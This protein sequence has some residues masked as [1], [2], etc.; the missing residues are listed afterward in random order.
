[1]K[2]WL[3][4][5]VLLVGTSGVASA[6]ELL[7]SAVRFEHK[8]EAIKMIEGGADVNA[9]SVDGTT[10]LHWAAYNDDVDL[11]KRLLAKGADP[12]ARNDY[13]ATPMQA[14]AVA[15]DPAVIKP[16]L[17]AGA[18]PELDG[19]RRTDGSNGRRP[20]G[21]CRG[22]QGSYRPRGS[23]ECQGAPA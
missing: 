8:A 7:V 1:M 11:V 9:P 12:N 17:K 2:A 19:R 4:A 16:L 23:R 5:V 6:S 22:G 21:Q 13:N 20:V 10:A 15:A 14:A 3:L 18:D